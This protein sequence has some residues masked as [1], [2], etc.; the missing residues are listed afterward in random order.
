MYHKIEENVYW[1][2]YLGQSVMASEVYEKDKL[3]QVSY[4]SPDL[5]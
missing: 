5:E 3:H 4:V 2:N 1:E